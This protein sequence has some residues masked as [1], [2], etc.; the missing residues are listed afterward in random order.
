MVGG[1]PVDLKLYQTEESI[2]DGAQSQI[3]VFIELLLNLNI[4]L[5]GL[6]AASEIYSEIKPKDII[7]P[8]IILS[9][10]QDLS[11]ALENTGTSN[12]RQLHTVAVPLPFPRLLLD[13][14]CLMH[15]YF[16]W[17]SD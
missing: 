6:E 9:K 10:Y 1:L 5:C 12:S 14:W 16:E 8:V 15:R 7:R 4:I 13:I 11:L 2:Y 17:L 3:W